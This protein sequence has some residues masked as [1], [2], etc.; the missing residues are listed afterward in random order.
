MRWME[1][2]RMAMVSLFRRGQQTERL[3][4]EMRFHLEQEVAERIRA[5]VAPEEA[6]RAAMRE[7]GNPAV[8]REEARR[9]WSWGW[10]ESMVRGVRFGARS[11]RRSPGFTV[12][13]AAAMALC[14]GAPPTLFTVVRWVP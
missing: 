8:L 1:R 10:L 13:A 6:R 4:A 2:L 3:D 12:T 9:S 11:L 14:I 7:F 5:G